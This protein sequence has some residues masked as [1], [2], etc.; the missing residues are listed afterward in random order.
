MLNYSK[1]NSIKHRI[2]DILK[3]TTLFSISDKMVRPYELFRWLLERHMFFKEA[4]MHYRNDKQLPGSYKDY[5]KAFWKHRV[6]YSEYMDRYEYWKLNEQQ[7]N[8]FISRSEMQCI[9]RKLGD[10]NVMN[11]FYDKTHF[12][13][14]FHEFI[15]RKWIVVKESSLDEFKRMIETMDCIA[16]PIE[17]TAGQGIFKISAKDVDNWEDLYKKCINE[18]ILLEECIQSDEKLKAFHPNSLNTIRV[19]TVSNGGRFVVFGAL[20]RMGAHGSVVDNTHAGGVFAPINVESGT[21]DIEAVDSYNN[22]YR[23]HPDTQKQIVGFQIPRWNEIV[24]TCRKASTTIPNIRFAGWDVCV[25]KDGMIEMIEGN[26]APDF[27]GGM[28]APLKIGVKKQIQQTIIDVLGVDPIPYISVWK[29]N[30]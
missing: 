13:K 23:C 26:H 18:N 20:F 14:T 11:V 25:T 4:K 24:E 15:H 22:H 28:Q 1:M 19:V 29:K 2:W 27:D 30:K 6:T 8:E 16:K 7:R 9:Y 10:L 17:G 3:Q 12:L 5:K 21:I